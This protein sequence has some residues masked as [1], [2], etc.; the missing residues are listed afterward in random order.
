MIKSLLMTKKK[1]EV[2]RCRGWL[3]YLLFKGL[4]QLGFLLGTVV[5]G[6]SYMKSIGYHFHKFNLMVFV[7]DYF[8]YL[9]VTLIS[10]VFIALLV[11]NQF[12]EKYKI[13]IN[14][15]KGS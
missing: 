15:S 14:G 7:S 2:I 10:G 8:I 5:L 6:L 9:P 11:W 12:E 13:R 3:H 1:W 4:F